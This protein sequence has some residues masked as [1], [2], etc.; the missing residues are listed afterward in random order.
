MIRWEPIDRANVPGSDHVLELQ[1]RGDEWSM[2]VDGYELMNSRQH[3]SE[4]AL[5]QLGCK[6]IAARPR[7]RVMIGGLGMGY[8]LTAAL[9]QLGPRAEVVV[10]ELVPQ[11]VE[12][13]RG[14]LG[15]LA[16][17]PL[18]DRRVRIELGDVGALIAAARDRYDAILLDVDNGP[19]GLTRE[20]NEALYGIA[21][22]RRAFT[23]LRAG[24]VLGVWSSARAPAFAQRV[25]RAGFA[26]EEHT[27]RGRGARGGAR[28][29]LWMAHKPERPPV[30]RAKPV[31]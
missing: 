21:A 2:R 23:A 25:R 22:L 31:R 16:G 12:W 19:A 17:H 5:C 7:A 11:V 8:S 1:R 27:A 3:G 18:R 15:P 14:P 24:G 13:N 6:P 4:E 20:E 10:S 30:A 9:A 28:H 29:T 26:L